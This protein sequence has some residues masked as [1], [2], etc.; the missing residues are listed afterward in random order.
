MKA[1]A[2]PLLAA[3][4]VTR[5]APALATD[6]GVTLTTTPVLVVPASPSGGRERLHLENLETGPLAPN[7][8]CSFSLTASSSPVLGPSVPGSFLIAPGRPITLG[9]NDGIPGEPLWCVSDTLDGNLTV[10]FTAQ[11]RQAGL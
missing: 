2:L 11:T 9:E 5:G 4:I 7:A 6:I 1:F 8:W 3:L 10:R